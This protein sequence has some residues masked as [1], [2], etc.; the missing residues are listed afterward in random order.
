M[1]WFDLLLFVLVFFNHPLSSFLSLRKEEQVRSQTLPVKQGKL[2]KISKLY[3]SWLLA[4]RIILRGYS[5]IWLSL[6]GWESE[7]RLSPGESLLIQNLGGLLAPLAKHSNIWSL[8]CVTASGSGDCLAL[9]LCLNKSVS[10]HLVLQVREMNCT[11]R[12]LE[13]DRLLQWYSFYL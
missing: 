1:V 4:L 10:T 9:L 12:W 2:K 7:I 3:M 11:D 6:L 8:A 13:T 5:L